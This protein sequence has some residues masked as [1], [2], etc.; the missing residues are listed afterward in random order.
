MTEDERHWFNRNG[1][2][3]MNTIAASN[4][5]D[6]VALLANEVTYSVQGDHGG[7]QADNQQIPIMFSWPGLKAGKRLQTPIRNV[8]ILPTILEL[9]GIAPT[10]SLDGSAVKLPRGNN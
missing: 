4:G 8:D 1:Q 3:L 5:P 10:H 9:L 6:A 2:K 7:H